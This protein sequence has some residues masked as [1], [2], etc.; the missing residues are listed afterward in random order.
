MRSFILLLLLTLVAPAVRSTAAQPNVE[1]IWSQGGHNAFTDLIRFQDRWLCTFREGDGHVSSRGSVRVLVSDNGKAW[2]SGALLT[3]AGIDLRDP[4]LSVT[5]DGR[6]MMVMGGSVMENGLYIDRQTRVSFSPNGISWCAPIKILA[7]LD[8]LWR[9]TWFQGKAYGVAYRGG[10]GMRGIK[11][12]AALYM[13][14]DG[15]AWK[16]ITSLDLPGGSETTLR[17]LDDGE[18]IALSV[19][20]RT[21]PRAT[22]IGSSR[23]PYA[24]WKWQDVA[25]AIG[26]P[27]FLILPN[28]EWLAGCRYYGPDNSHA[29]TVLATMT[30]NS[31]T[32][33]MT[34]PSGGD[35]SYPGMVLHNSELWMSYYSSH[36]GKTNIYLTRVPL[37]LSKE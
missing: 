11:R 20:M 4:K 30:R 15:L 2:R 35:N 1:K 24:S 13:S 31:L 27:N 17:F 32:P 28:G 26:G 3:E 36:E 5:P 22:R 37:P 10:G 21:R 6:L 7:P 18:M 9:V 34:F 8:W 19:D 12:S 25:F 23:P 14:E 29:K 16:R 33:V